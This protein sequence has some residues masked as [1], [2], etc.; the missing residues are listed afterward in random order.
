MHELT[1][2]MGTGPAFCQAL[3]SFFQNYNNGGFLNRFS[4]F[5]KYKMTPGVYRGSLVSSIN[6][7]RFFRNRNVTANRAA[8]YRVMDAPAEAPM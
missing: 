4:L 8:K 5:F 7:I 6:Y 2:I 1:C 3:P